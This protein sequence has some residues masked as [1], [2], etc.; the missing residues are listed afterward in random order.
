MGRSL[1]K[2]ESKIKAV[3][4]YQKAMELD[5]SSAI[6]KNKLNELKKLGPVPIVSGYN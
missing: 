3:E 5:P 4:F 1:R 2:N 6:A